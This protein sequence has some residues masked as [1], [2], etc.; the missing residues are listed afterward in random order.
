M[1][2]VYLSFSLLL[3]AAMSLSAQTLWDNFEDTRKGTYGFINGTFIPY[4]ENPAP[5]GSNTSLIAA[6]YTRNPAELFD[7][8]VYDA[9]MADLSDYLSGAKTMTMD[10]WSPAAGTTVQI[11][12]END[13]LAEPANFPTG[14][15]SAYL[16]TTSVA[17]GWETLTFTFDNQPDASVSN[18]N[19]NRM[20][21]LFA[22]NTNTGETYY[23]DNLNGPELAN[24][25]CEGAVSNPNIFNDFECNQNTNYTF[26]HSGINFRRVLNPDT[27]GNASDYAA[28]YTRNAG[29]LIDVI[30]GR[31]DGNL[32][33][34]AGNTITL[35]V[36][37][38]AAPTPILISLQNENNEV[39]LEMTQSTSISSGWETLTFDP[40]DVVDATD[41]SRFAILFDP[42]TDSSD[43]FYWDNF[44]L[45]GVTSITN[46]SEV[47]AFQAT[48][49]PSQG[50]TTF[51]YNLE[52]AANVN[53]SV[54]DMNGK[55]VS[56]VV[57]E[58]QAAGAHQATWLANDLP[59]GI[60]FYNMLINGATAS[61]KIVLNK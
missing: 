37:D 4:Q 2:K 41:I 10:V 33:L 9:Q 59:N 35:D 36:W 22:P 58:N 6:E 61:G 45:N 11:T 27:N 12:L 52:N 23:W 60:Y 51:Q 17:Q 44:Q 1:K 57:S 28:T 5:G 15:H 20:V 34:E 46:L 54:F 14:R 43:Q 7:V 29:E 31:F 16:A 18:T 30:V 49:N 8:I 32:S 50:E 42:N 56:Q 19:V 48:P 55:L 21:I 26:S 39:I 53:L 47:S 40:S 38:A 25:P 13:V 24:D 3:L